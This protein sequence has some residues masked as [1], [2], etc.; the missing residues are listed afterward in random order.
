M[1]R[2]AQQR[3]LQAVRDTAVECGARKAILFGSFARGTATRR[4]DVDAVF[5]EETSARFLER[6]DRY[7]RGLYDRLG[8]PAEVFVY[9]PT[10]FR[11]M[12]DQP[13]MKRVLK[14][15]IVAYEC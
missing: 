6:L 1:D 5:V 9:T 12:A 7:M 3:V 10:E 14:E 4:S 13:F 15:G 2:D 11:T 8:I